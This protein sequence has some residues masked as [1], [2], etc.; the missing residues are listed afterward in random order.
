[1]G[2]YTY[3]D[4]P[5][6]VELVPGYY[7]KFIDMLENGEYWYCEVWHLRHGYITETDLYKTQATAQKHA[8][9]LLEKHLTEGSSSNGKAQMADFI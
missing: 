4:K 7:A 6:N 5:L 1:M 3:R 9:E 8:A 2:F